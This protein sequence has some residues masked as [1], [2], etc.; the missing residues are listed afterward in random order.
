[1]SKGSK[2]AT[3]ASPDRDTN[4]ETEIL[5]KFENDIDLKE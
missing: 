1:M 3:K 2:Q 5:S 4:L